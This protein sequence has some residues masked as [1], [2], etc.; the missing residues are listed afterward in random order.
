MQL[1]CKIVLHPGRDEK[2]GSTT[3]EQ[4]DERQNYIFYAVKQIRF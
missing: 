2:N 4:L 3:D 1:N